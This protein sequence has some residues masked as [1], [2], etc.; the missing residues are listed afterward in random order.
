MWGKGSLL[1]CA[2][3][4]YLL[5]RYRRLTRAASPAARYVASHYWKNRSIG[6]GVVAWR[7]AGLPLRTGECFGQEFE[8]NH[9]TGFWF[10]AWRVWGANRCR[11]STVKD[12]HEHLHDSDGGWRDLPSIL[13]S[14]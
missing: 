3:R 9:C 8:I 1:D 14:F 11:L 5:I 2:S 7:A 6:D 10:T 4:S 12:H 13:F